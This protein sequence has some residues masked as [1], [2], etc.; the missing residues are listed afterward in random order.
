M[1]FTETNLT[2]ALDELKRLSERKKDIVVEST[3]LLY[4]DGKLTFGSL[5]IVPNDYMIGQMAQRFKIPT[6]YV[7]RMQSLAPDLLAQN[8]NHWF[9]TDDV[10]KVLVRSYSPDYGRAMLSDQYLEIP[11][12][13]LVTMILEVVSKTSKEIGFEMK[14][15]ITQLTEKNCYMKFSFPELEIPSKVIDYFKD[16]ESQST[17]KGYYAGMIFR[18]SEVGAGMFELSPRIIT[19][20]CNNGVV[21]TKRS[22]KKYHMGER[23]EVGELT[24]SQD[25]LRSELKTLLL[26]VRDATTLWLSPEYVGKRV[27]EIEKL[28]ESKYENPVEVT[29]NVCEHMLLSKNDSQWVVNYLMGC[30]QG[31]NAYGIA[32]GITALAKQ[33]DPD[34]SA[35]LERWVGGLDWNMAK[36]K[37]PR[38][39]E[40]IN[41][42]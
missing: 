5:E 19:G 24:F 11:T 21:F 4:Q 20:A 39:L 14:V 35:N 18:N 37:T 6:A 3:K 2:V 32:Q 16:T 7:R 13:E 15:D 25:T 28:S 33:K 12:Y 10:R 41:L 26:K 42:N 38:K 36:F 40:S 8:F 30:G 23:M 29:L 1:T 17:K 27:E 31:D 34:T 22:V 9:K